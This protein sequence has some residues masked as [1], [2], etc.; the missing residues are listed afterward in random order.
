MQTLSQEVQ[1]ANE[2]ALGTERFLHIAEKYMD[3]QELTP[4]I[5]RELIEK[6]EVSEPVKVN[7]KK[8]I[9]KIR[10]FYNFIGEISLPDNAKVA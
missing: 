2:K 3:L 6:I 10:I 4:T 8:R 1:L 5:L 9:Q 7:G